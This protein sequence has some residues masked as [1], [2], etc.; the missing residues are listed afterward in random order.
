MTTTPVPADALASAR[1]RTAATAAVVALPLL[2]LVVLDHGA[3]SKPLWSDEWATWQ[4][5]G[6]SWPDLWRATSHVDRDLLPYYGLVH[7]ARDVGSGVTAVRLLSL[8]GAGVAVV[9]TQ[10]V[11]RR[12]WGNLAALVAGLVL[13]VNPVFCL[14][15]AQARP[16][17]FAYGFVAV[18]SWLVVR[19]GRRARL[20]HP[21]LVTAGALIF[22]T[23]VLAVPAQLIWLWRTAGRGAA[24]RAALVLAP[25]VLAVAVWELLWVGQVSELVVAS[26][27]GAAD[28]VRSTDHALGAEG[29]LPWLHVVAVLAAAAALAAHR[30]GGHDQARRG[31]VF[32]LVLGDGAVAIAWAATALGVP[33][34]ADNLLVTVPVAAALLLAGL[35]GHA[36]FVPANADA[37][38]GVAFR[39]G[40]AVAT[41]VALAFAGSWW[42]GRARSDVSL[43]GMRFVAG[44]IAGHAAVGDVLV[45]QQPYSTVGYTASLAAALDDRALAT[46]LVQSLPGGAARTVVRRVTAVDAARDRVATEPAALRGDAGRVWVVHLPLDRVRDDYRRALRCQH[47]VRQRAQVIQTDLELFSCTPTF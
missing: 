14:W 34:L 27:A 7:L 47:P 10:L 37:D 43:D 13:V 36:W 38:W 22:P 26:G 12:V 24:A 32:A 45:L 2:V 21:M 16:T 31:L 33:T 5:S 18:G 3:V 46:S 39:G 6:L 44:T 1:W 11:A 19:G 17:A 20:F 23:T 25:G 4:Y 9:A 15:A 8:A 35:V 40:L 29:G 41:L 42:W 28:V 30:G